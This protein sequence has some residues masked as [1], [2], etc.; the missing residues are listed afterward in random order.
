MLELLTKL[1]PVMLFWMLAA[2]YL[3]GWAVELRGGKGLTQIL[4]LL[5]NFVLFVVVWQVLHRVF[6]GFGPILGGIVITSFI[7]A[8]LL[9]AVAWLGYKMVGVTVTPSHGGH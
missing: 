7:A 6:L 8:A 9:P 4:G 5:L 1:L 2:L 3:G